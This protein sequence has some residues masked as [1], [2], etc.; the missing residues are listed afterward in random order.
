M[1][2]T[3]PLDPARAEARPALFGG[4]GTVRV[5]N[6]G[7]CTPPFSAVLFCELDGGGR[8]GKHRQDRDDEVVIVVG[9]E[10]V[11]FVDGRSHAAVRGTAVALP[12]GSTLE[13]DNASPSEVL[14][15][16]I[17]KARRAA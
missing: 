17:V 9:G 15:Y 5:W 6:M 13:I 12:L 16:V 7:A 1:T 3:H 10:G 4:T 14:S 8:V 2:P 11:V